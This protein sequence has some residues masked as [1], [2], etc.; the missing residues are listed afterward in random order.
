MNLIVRLRNGTSPAMLRVL[1]A[2]M[3]FFQSAHLSVL[4][5]AFDEQGVGGRAPAM[6]DAFTAVSDDA[7]AIMYNPA[8]LVQLT[9]GEF[10][11]QYGQ[12]VRGLD[13]GSSLGTTYLGF[14]HPLR[15]GYRVVGLGYH[16]FKADNLFTERT[17]VLSYGQRLRIAPFG[18]QGIWSGGV[19]VKQL[20]H[21]Y[22]PDRFTENALNDAGTGTG[23]TDPLFS[24]GYGKG[25]FATDLGLLYQFGPGYKYTA[26]LTGTNLN[27]PDLS[28]RNAGDRAPSVVKMGLAYR[29]KWGT[30]SA[31]MRRAKRLTSHSDSEFAMGAERN[32]VTSSIGALVVR[33]GYGEGSRGFKALTAGLGYIY[34][35]F[36][37]D[38]AFNFP[39]E[40]LSDTSGSHRIGFSM[41]MGNT[42][43]KLGKDYSQI[44]LLAAFASN[45]LTTHVLLT[46]YAL[47]RRMPAV[48]KDYA[49]MILMRKYPLDDEGLQDARAELKDVVGR[50][51]TE[52]M[53]WQ[54]L[55]YN[56][57]R[58]IPEID[59]SNVE[60][61]LEFLV[62][63]DAKSTL[64]RLALLPQNVQK[65]VRIQ[66]VT[67]M[68]LAELSAESYRETN[69]DTCIDSV[70]RVV[71]ILPGDEVVMRAYRQLLLM[72]NNMDKQIKGESTVEVSE[73]M[74]EAPRELVAPNPDE[75][76][77]APTS[78]TEKEIIAR[79]FATSLGYYLIRKS[80]GA[81]N[82]ELRHLLNQMKAVYGSSGMDVSVVD[83]ELAAL[84]LAQPEPKQ[85]VIENIK[86]D[87]TIM[88]KDVA[89]TKAKPSTPEKKP[90]S[91][92]KPTKAP[93]AKPVKKSAPALPPEWEQA[94][95]YYRQ[96]A[97]RDITDH[98]K[99][100]LLEAML[101]RFGE[102]GAVQINKELQR[103]RKRL[104]Q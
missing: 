73:E 81:S 62:K 88:K 102:K 104:E 93:A 15:L 41:K 58:E 2:F 82:E 21:Q 80:N 20:Y 79:N 40:A 46:R 42:P 25:A 5:S 74:P 18:W 52:S 76:Q 86:G 43:V 17:I 101:A 8:G 97:A 96:A 28:L 16:N 4:Q 98:E 24:S 84:G 30:L 7:N 51:T 13:D 6:G 32:I 66:T 27:R 68:A 85:P 11:T 91:T 64:A 38:Y 92:N 35:K 39:I 103:I 36:R 94:W 71:D 49:L 26:G 29:P 67:M 31:E 63:G 50:R 69:I 87:S 37:L 59:R 34:S 72:R 48:D 44:N 19:N 54:K 47:D 77:V 56:F 70:R 14:A 89:P 9:D 75:S 33:A 57:V 10:S 45:S 90:A 53:D 55:K 65:A 99:I 60:H 12:L 3:L 100:E 95:T 61:A 22:Q 1:L 83:K 78:A 23:Q